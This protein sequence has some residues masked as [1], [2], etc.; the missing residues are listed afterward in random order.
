MSQPRKHHFLPEFYLKGFCPT[1]E[2]WVYDREKGQYRKL[3][4]ETV[5]IRKDFYSVEGP[6]GEKDHAEVERRLG[7]IENQAAPAIRKLDAG[8][9]LTLRERYAL[10]LFAALLKFRTPTFERQTEEMN[11]LFADPEAAKELVAADVETARIRLTQA[12]YGGPM[13]PELARAVYEYIHAE[14]IQHQ[15]GP[16]AR[17]EAMLQNAHKLATE[18]VLKPWTVA[19]A[20][21]GHY[22]GTADHPYAVVAAGGVQDPLSL[23]GPD[24]IPRAIK[25][26]CL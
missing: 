6:N 11:G 25:H 3:R 1:G 15:P 8:S 7:V 24:I 18:L 16:N 20:P 5:A 19:R 21:E 14:G 2:M 26:G 9:R 17:L 23:E 22:F 4:P 12:G 10:A 13:L